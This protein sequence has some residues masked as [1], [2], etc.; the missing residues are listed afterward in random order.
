LCARAF[1]I[2]Y[3]V[4]VVVVV[5]V[6]SRRSHVR[7]GGVRVRVRLLLSAMVADEEG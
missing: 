1:N 6:T 7:C 5:I 2:H 3:V 4:V